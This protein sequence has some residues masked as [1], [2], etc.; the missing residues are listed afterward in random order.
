MGLKASGL[1]FLG[2]GLGLSA[3]GFQLSAGVHRVEDSGSKLGR[4]LEILEKKV[5]RFE[6]TSYGSGLSI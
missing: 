4:G 1:K 2:V 5:S 3:Q 6:A